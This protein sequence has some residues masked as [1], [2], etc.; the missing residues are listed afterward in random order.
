MKSSLAEGI[1]P[2]V[3]RW[4]R[5]SIGLG[6]DEV[7]ARL[8][9]QVEEIEAWEAGDKA[10]TWP[11]LEKLAYK[12]YKRPIALFFLPE[13]PTEIPPITEF[14]TLPV[15]E[16]EQLLPDTRLHI[17]KAHAYQ[18]ALAEIF[19]NK[20]PSERMIWKDCAVK[21][22]VEVSMLAKQVRHYLGV[23]INQQS[24]WETPDSAFKFWR[25]AVEDKGVFVFKAAFKQK[26][27]SGFC[28]A[29]DQLPVIYLN[30]STTKT[31]QVFSLLHELCHLL[32]HENGLSKFEHSYIEQLPNSVRKLERLCNALA[33]EILIPLVDFA[34][35]SRNLPQ[36]IE[37]AQSEVIAQLASRYGVSREAILRRFLDQNRVSTEYYEQKAKEWAAQ[38]RNNKGGDWYST[39]NAY[40]SERFATEVVSRH[41]R[42]QLS[43][44]HAADLLGIKA[45]NFVGL[46]QRILQSTSS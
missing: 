30:N 26:D 7:A 37:D 9:R 18:L 23:N 27:I 3:L 11:Q 2:S 44:E 10:P 22:D 6:L 1:Q 34:A 5:E 41:Y 45:K 42:N 40:L 35:Q 19:Q 13:P 21:D 4:A 43:L 29:D 31:R 38:Q 24:Q 14:R 8:K 15:V 20:S 46:E 33:A 39:T 16:M 25:K 32:V 17:R 12:I 36:K 28:L